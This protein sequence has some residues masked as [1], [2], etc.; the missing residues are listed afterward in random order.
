MEAR[1]LLPQG[2]GAIPEHLRQGEVGPRPPR[3]GL[4]PWALRVL[5]QDSLEP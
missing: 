3:A 2:R 4:A 5:G 1:G